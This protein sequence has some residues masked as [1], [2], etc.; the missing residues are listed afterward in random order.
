MLLSTLI[1][2]LPSVANVGS[3][4]L[5]LFFVFAYMGGSCTWQAVC[6]PSEHAARMKHGLS[7]CP[8][9][10]MR[11]GVLLF[12]HVAWGQDLNQHANFTTFPRALL[13]LFRVATGDNWAVLL[14]D[15]MVAP[16][17]CDRAAGNCGHAWAPIYF[18]S[19]YLAGGMIALNLVSRDAGMCLRSWG[20]MGQRG[21]ACEAT[22]HLPFTPRCRS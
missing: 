18:F 4:L 14:R 12:G 16:P 19:F 20:R 9:P 10:P 2:S 6:K 7:H 5:L 1:I 22:M 15:C 17:L 13:L 8:L 21:A 3:L 11:A